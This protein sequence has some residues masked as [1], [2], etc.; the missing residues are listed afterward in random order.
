MSDKQEMLDRQLRRRGISDQRI[1]DAMAKVP[2][3]E[4][5]DPELREQA[6]EDRPLAIGCRQ[7]VSQPYIVASMLQS[8]APQ[9][10]DCVLEIGT[11]SGYQTAL[12]A[13]LA[14]RILSIERHPEL[15]ET[16]RGRLQAMGYA[17]VRVV[18]GDGTLGYP[19]EAPYDVIL[20]SAA[21]PQ[22]PPSL[23]DQLAM[24]GRMIIPVGNLEAQQLVLVRRGEAGIQASPLDGC[25][26]VPLIGAEGFHG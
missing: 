26:F 8:V 2:R 1:L 3:Q 22:V 9:S 24:N 19:Y 5:V 10:S 4:F 20:V 6:Y 16:A 11:G 15:A 21:A 23:A 18:V 12:L 25:V 13:E 7:T 17:N 14:R